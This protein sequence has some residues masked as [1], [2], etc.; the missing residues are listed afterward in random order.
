MTSSPFCLFSSSS[1]WLTET[2]FWLLR[3][4]KRGKGGF[5]IWIIRASNLPMSSKTTGTLCVSRFTY[6]NM[7]CRKQSIEPVLLHYFN[8]FRRHFFSWSTK[9]NKKKFLFISELGLTKL[10]CHWDSSHKISLDTQCGH[11]YDSYVQVGSELLPMQFNHSYSALPVAMETCFSPL[12][13]SS[14]FAVKLHAAAE[15]QRSN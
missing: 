14:L 15:P 8:H 4:P 11:I 2:S 7:Q 10:A 12:P 6:L 5:N 1:S 3:T 13:V 9:K